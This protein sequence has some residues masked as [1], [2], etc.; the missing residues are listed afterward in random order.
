M[1][2]KSYENKSIYSII[3]KVTF[4]IFLFFAL[5]STSLPFQDRTQDIDEIGT[6]NKVN[7]IVY[8]MIFI[9]A[10]IS[11][12]SKRQELWKI[13]K[14]EKWL[15]IFLCWC[16]I[17]ISWSQFGFV[18]F[19]RLFQISTGF[20]A[21]STILLYIENEQELMKYMKPIVYLYLILTLLSIVFIPAARDPL[22]VNAFRGL[23]P[24]KN[25]LG[26]T[27]IV[28]ML[29]TY[30]ISH[31]E[32]HSFGKILSYIMIFIAFILLIGTKSST[33][34]L[35]FS[36]MLLIGTLV[37]LNSIL[38]T[39]GIGDMFIYFSILAIF[40]F[41]FAIYKLA[42]D[43]IAFIPDLFQ[44]DLT[45]SGRID[46]WQYMMNEIKQHLL[47]GTGFQGF[48][49]LENINVLILYEKFVWLPLQA[50]NGYI[51]LLNEL[52]FIGLV[53]FIILIINYFYHLFKLDIAHHWKLFVIL[54]LIHNLQETTLF[55]PGHIT[56]IFFIF[57]YLKLFA[58]LNLKPKN[59]NKK[60]LKYAI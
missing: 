42:P 2:E 8:S 41:A 31:N 57:A 26:Q 16:L 48:W 22:F 24:H 56:S 25:L 5:F 33:S 13:I 50:H 9:G 12:I 30:I 29:L 49:V 46:L 43:A 34:I 14:K 11:L 55:R 28:C 15:T 23:T 39:I 37:Y 36:I 35:N 54:V 20:F 52:G 6:S 27:S 18:S 7:Q 17:S 58:E 51:D 10:I 53:L 32:T 47:Y 60:V 19:K 44:K 40:G 45:F 1:I 4:V 59:Q 38:K 3:A 21:C